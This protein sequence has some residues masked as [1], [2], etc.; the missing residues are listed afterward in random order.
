MRTRWRNAAQTKMCNTGLQTKATGR[1]AQCSGGGGLGLAFL[2]T[3]SA[4]PGAWGEQAAPRPPTPEGLLSHRS[5]FRSAHARPP[6]QDPRKHI[7]QP[8]P[9][10]SPCGSPPRGL[11]L[12]RV[13][14]QHPP[15]YVRPP[16][17]VPTC[18]RSCRRLRS[19]RARGDPRERGGGGR[20][21]VGGA[22]EDGHALAQ[23][24]LLIGC[25]PLARAQRGRPATAPLKAPPGGSCATS[26][27]SSPPPPLLP[28]PA[29]T[30]RHVSGTTR[31][32][33]RAPG[34]A[35]GVGTARRHSLEGLTL[36]G[37]ALPP[38]PVPSPEPWGRA[39]GAELSVWGSP[40]RH[41]PCSCWEGAHRV[42]LAVKQ[43]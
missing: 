37:P 24:W 27:R 6:T 35:A 3:H 11:G 20:R 34:R 40:P 14:P 22:A 23:S 21:A 2:G 7:E 17:A 25:R 41:P 42:D 18:S 5:T 31:A 12:S 15:R 8:P 29:P 26:A 9:S 10:P 19:A 4:P 39:W 38:G 13:G 1:R 33:A 32:S 36:P 16:S 43:G 28:R 30:L